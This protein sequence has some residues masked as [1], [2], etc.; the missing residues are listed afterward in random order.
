MPFRDDLI[1][2]TI[3][4]LSQI[5][6]RM[7]LHQTSY[8]ELESFV[9]QAYQKYTGIDGNILRQLSSQD[10]LNTLSTTGQVDKEKA[11]LIA[12]LLEA[13]SVISEQDQESLKLKALD[14]YLEVAL[15][16][17]GIE[18]TPQRIQKLA[19]ELEGFILPKV[20]EFRLMDY[21]L[22]QGYYAQVE[23]RLFDLRGRLGIEAVKAKGLESYS[24]LSKLSHDELEKGGLSQEEVQSGMKDFLS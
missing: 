11:Y 12:A 8:A 23:D 18:D 2:R 21:D 13:E 22:K 6:S 10:I 24:Y 15:A 16:D 3:E 5:L 1:E 20:T 14:L 7:L 17:S 4:Q 9:Q 19:K